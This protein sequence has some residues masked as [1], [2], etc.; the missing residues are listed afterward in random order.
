MNVKSIYKISSASL[1]SFLGVN[2]GNEPLQHARH[3]RLVRS[4]AGSPAACKA[5]EEPAEHSGVKLLLGIRLL[6]L[7][8]LAVSVISLVHC[9]VV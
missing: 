5:F 3:Q 4:Q 7:I 2:L 8:S 9:P 1:Y 6:T